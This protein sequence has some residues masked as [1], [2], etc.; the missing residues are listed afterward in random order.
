MEALAWIIL[1]ICCL[2][3]VAGTVLPGLPG[4]ALIVTGALVHKLLLPQFLSWWVVAAIGVLALVSV[5]IDILGS[6]LGAKWGG[7]SRRGMIGTAVGGLVGLFFLPLGIIVGPVI[8][9]FAGEY[10]GS[11]PIR[12][13]A[14]AGVGAGVGFAVSIVIRMCVA[15]AAIVTLVIDLIV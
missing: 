3:G 5:F 14:R 6:L 7:A 8:G 12:E 9:A 15:G 11:R 1:A 4:V 10:L 13:A 2:L